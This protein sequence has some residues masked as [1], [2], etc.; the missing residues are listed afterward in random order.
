M[1]R[2][3]LIKTLMMISN[4]KKNFGLLVYI[5]IPRRLKSFHL[6]KSARDPEL[7]NDQSRR[8]N[9]K[10]TE[11]PLPIRKILVSCL[12]NSSV[13]RMTSFCIDTVN[14]ALNQRWF[15]VDPRGPTLNLYWVNTSRFLGMSRGRQSQGKSQDAGQCVAATS[16]LSL[17]RVHVNVESNQCLCASLWQ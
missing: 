14:P 11:I 7:R 12:T 8:G 13:I 10:L 16:L 2:E 9:K 3:K 4:W 6:K 17:H 5:K 15:I 1:K